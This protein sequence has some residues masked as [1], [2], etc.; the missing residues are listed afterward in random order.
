[1]I[2]YFRRLLG[3]AL[4]RS[5]QSEVDAAE[6][7]DES[8]RDNACIYFADPSLIGSR[9]FDRLSELVEYEGL[10]DERGFA[11][12]VL[13]TLEPGTVRMTFMPSHDIEQH[14]RDFEAFVQDAHGGE[15]DKVY[16][17]ARIR[18]ARVVAGCV[19]EPGFDD[20]GIIATFLFRLSSEWNGMLFGGSDLYDS[21]GTE[22][23]S[24]GPASE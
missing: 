4:S 18:A 20:D 21:D 1:M 3:S 8:P 2:R 5:R 10:S 22:L 12:G 13:F 16:I 19:I 15:D 6:T 7:S 23:L 9:V 24:F 11:T 14:L 17:R